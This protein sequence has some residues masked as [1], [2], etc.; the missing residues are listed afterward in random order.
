MKKLFFTLLCLTFFQMSLAQQVIIKTNPLNPIL[1]R[2]TLGLEVA[3][4]EHS[5]LSLLVSRSNLSFDKFDYETSNGSEVGGEL[6]LTSWGFMP[7]YRYYISEQALKGFYIGSYANYARMELD[8]SVNGGTDET[9]GY[10]NAKFNN[11]GLGIMTGYNFLINDQFSIDVFG[12]LG[13]FWYNLSKVNIKYQNDDVVEEKIP[14]PIA[15]LFPRIGVN[16]G[17]AF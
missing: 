1:G 6:E 11:Y 17:Y 10:A 8:I 5:S 13:G 2:Y 12:G 16:L 9:S 14:I 3:I 4:T 15:G 7:E